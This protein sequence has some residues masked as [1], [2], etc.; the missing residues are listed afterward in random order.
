M[1]LHL[2]NRLETQGKLQ[3]LLPNFCTA[4]GARTAGEGNAASDAND[5][6]YARRRDDAT[7]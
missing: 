7:S 5:A 1:I 6:A 2:N 4:M 3:G